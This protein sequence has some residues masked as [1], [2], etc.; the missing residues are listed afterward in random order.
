MIQKERVYVVANKSFVFIFRVCWTFGKKYRY[1]SS[2]LCGRRTNPGV[3]EELKRGVSK[4][5]KWKKDWR[6]ICKEKKAKSVSRAP[7]SP[8]NYWGTSALWAPLVS[9]SP[10]GLAYS[11]S[12]PF[13]GHLLLVFQGRT[14]CV[15][16]TKLQYSDIME[17][18]NEYPR[19]FWASMCIHFILLS[20]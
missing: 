6:P 4:N 5:T 19:I 10:L 12:R 13:G 11:V 7:L 3:L 16:C 1:D 15:W 17:I 2:M 9:S 8:S 14:T 18:V 20:R